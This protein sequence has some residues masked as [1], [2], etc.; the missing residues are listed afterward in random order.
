MGHEPNGKVISNAEIIVHSN[1]IVQKYQEVCQ[2]KKDLLIGIECEKIGVRA[3]TGRTA[4][5]YGT[6]GYLAILKKLRDELGWKVIQEQNGTIFE[7]ERGRGTRIT[8]ESD[9]RIEFTGSPYQTIHDVAREFRIHR[10]EIQEISNIFQ[11]AWLGLGFQPISQIS[12]V[13]LI[14]KMRSILGIRYRM[15]RG[16]P[17][18]QAWSKQTAS[19]QVNFD[20]TSENNMFQRFRTIIRISPIIAAMFANSPFCYGKLSRYLSHRT[21]IALRTDPERF[22]LPRNFYEGNF[23]FKDWV[24]YC[25]DI[26]LMYFFRGNEYI[27][28]EPVIT[29]R[30]FIEKGYQGHFPTIDDWYLHLSCIYPDARVRDYI[31]FRSCDSVPPDLVTAVAALVKGIVYDSHGYKQV[32]EMT[33]NWTYKE[34]ANLRYAIAAQALQAEIKGKKVLEYAKQLLEIA[35]HNLKKYHRLNEN[36]EDESIHLMPIKDYV[37]VREK[38]PA[39]CITEKWQGSWNKNIAKLI[40]WCRY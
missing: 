14:P 22:D 23:G 4:R 31:E 33:W 28:P 8:L 9:G 20:Y 16:L 6:R 26:P 7:L 19:V 12:E 11:I 24:E 36:N 17:Q 13:Q 32:Q 5:Y 25:L 1:Q 15:K 39:E 35:T 40:E 3:L 21:H 37:F 38:S 27:L 10:N 2:K 30:K 29:F 18:A 34:I